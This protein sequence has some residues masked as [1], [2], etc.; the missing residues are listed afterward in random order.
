M[1]KKFHRIEC[2]RERERE[3]ARKLMRT[4]IN[5]MMMGARQRMG[6]CNKY[7]YSTQLS[8]TIKWRNFRCRRHTFKYYGIAHACALFQI[9]GIEARKIDDDNDEEEVEEGKE[10]YDDDS[11]KEKRKSFVAVSRF[12]DSGIERNTQMHCVPV[13]SISK[14]CAVCTSRLTQL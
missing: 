9:F 1:P 2:E 12:E 5:L 3:R 10:E 8:I 11:G 6:G 14:W 7:I 4:Q 13:D